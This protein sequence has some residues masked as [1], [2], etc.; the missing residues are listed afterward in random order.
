MK[1][2]I[3]DPGQG[4]ILVRGRLFCLLDGVVLCQFRGECQTV[5]ASDL[6]T[7]VL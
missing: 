2:L 3:A 4:V 7:W 1:D 6:N 5:A